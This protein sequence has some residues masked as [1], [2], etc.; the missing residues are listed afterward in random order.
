LVTFPKAQKVHKRVRT[1][2]SEQIPDPF[3]WKLSGHA[4]SSLATANGQ[5]ETTV[6]D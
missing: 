4:L 2:L 3:I 5:A 6:A 1:V